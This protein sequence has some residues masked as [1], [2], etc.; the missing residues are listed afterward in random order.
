VLCEVVVC[1]VLCDALCDALC[2]MHCDLYNVLCDLLY[3]FCGVVFVVVIVLYG[4]KGVV[5][6]ME[7]MYD[8]VL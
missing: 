8:S 1:N 7:R 2:V 5:C 4:E 3:S 6:L